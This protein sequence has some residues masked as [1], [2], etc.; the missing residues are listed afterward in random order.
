VAPQADALPPLQE[1]GPA[2]EPPFGE[3]RGMRPEPPGEDRRAS[4]AS[5][6]KFRSLRHEVDAEIGD[7]QAESTAEAR[8]VR[9]VATHQPRSAT[10]PQSARSSWPQHGSWRRDVSP[11]DDAAGEAPFGVPG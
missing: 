9:R 10:L 1:R 8:T 11:L 3:C 4:T 7:I 6:S 2:A 5:I